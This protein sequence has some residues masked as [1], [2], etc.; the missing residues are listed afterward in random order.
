[1]FGRFHPYIACASLFFCVFALWGAPLSAHAADPEVEFSAEFEP[2]PA[3]A[4]EVVVLSVLARVPDQYHLYSLS[5]VSGGPKPLNIEVTGLKAEG[6]WHARAPSLERDENFDTNVEFYSGEV[7]HRRAFRVPEAEPGPRQ[8]EVVVSGQICNDGKCISI[9]KKR[10]GSFQSEL[11]I[12][13]GTPRAEFLQVAQLEGEEFPADRTVPVLE[14]SKPPTSSLG[15]EGLFSYLVLAFLAGLGALVTPCVFPMIPITVAFFSKFSEVSMRRTVTMAGV[16]SFTIISTFTVLG[17]L[18][19]LLFGAVG[20]QAISSSIAFNLFLALLL[21]LFALNLFGLFEI[22]VPNFLIARTSAR[23]ND[24]LDEKGSM[25][26]QM[27]GVLFMGLTFTMISFTCTVGFIGIVLAEAA[28]GNWFYP[29]LGMLSFSTAFALPFFFLAV[30]PSFADRLRGRAGDWMTAVKVSLGFLELAGSWKF[31]SNVDLLLR[32]GIVTRSLVLAA[33]TGI[34]SVAGLYLLRVFQLGE[35]S[36]SRQIGPARMLAAAGMLGMAAYSASG[37]S[38]T[39]SMGG[40]IDGWLPPAVYP[41]TEA[42]VSGSSHESL[43]WITDDIEKGMKTAKEENRPLFIDFTGY[44][45]TNCRFMEESVFPQGKVHERLDSMVLVRAYQDGP[46]G[47]EIADY[48]VEHFGTA[49]L[50]LYVIWDAG[51]GEL[52]AQHTVDKTSG[53]AAAFSRFLEQGLSK[54]KGKEAMVPAPETAKPVELEL[55]KTGEPVNF[56]FPGLVDGESFELK[57]LRGQWVLLNFWASWCAPCKKELREDFPAA[58]ED[59]PE[60]KFVTVAFDGEDSRAEALSFAEEVSLLKHVALLGGE[61][62]EEA[63]LP[64]AL[65]ASSSLPQTFLIDPNGYIVWQQAD[66]VDEALLQRVLAQTKQQ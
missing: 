8:V 33:W 41:G 5:K 65:V 28:R 44:T 38:S 22:Q 40:W 62:I 45:C 14:E 36:E 29:A 57:S 35:G 17:V 58:L 16:Y 2:S 25:G 18:V 3:R 47:E 56:S 37:I 61:D 49:A 51:R 4:G 54:W 24:L 19:S 10:G 1:M 46:R 39:R 52:L 23:E 15:E 64:A 66:S 7:T 59:S 6:P 26:A 32:W 27:L 20:M 11:R 55:K 50:P 30:F 9:A 53:A 43:S 42:E 12:E 34:F 48:Q 31:Y 21:S 63:G 60:V 13:A